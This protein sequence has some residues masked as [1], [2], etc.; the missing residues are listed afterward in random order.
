[1]AQRT[2]VILR[3]V[4]TMN[5][6]GRVASICGNALTLVVC[7]DAK[8][9]HHGMVLRAGVDAESLRSGSMV[10]MGTDEESGYVLVDSPRNVTALCIDDWLFWSAESH[11]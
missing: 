3:P 8:R 9:F 6:L 2:F 10:V 5:R 1:M 4:I 11:R 7:D